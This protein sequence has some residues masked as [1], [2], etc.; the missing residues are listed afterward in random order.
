VRIIF[1]ILIC[2]GLHTSSTAQLKDAFRHSVGAG[3][4]LLQN[5]E[6]VSPAFGVYYHPQIN[7]INR[8]SDFSMSVGLPV[9]L[10][11]HIKSSFVPNTFFYAKVP[12]ITEANI[13]H[14]ATHDFT[15]SVGMT[16]GGG[17]AM[18]YTDLGLGHGPVATLS[19]RTWIKH[20]SI[21][22]RYLGMFQIPSSD[23]SGI[24]VPNKGYHTHM[25]V[26]AFNMGDYLSK[27][28]QM[29][30]ISKW[31]NPFRN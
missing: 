10:G 31:M 8:F 30:K 1:V 3:V 28:R 15:N 11:A 23:E 21:T 24:A 14:Y 26:L 2:F 12:L 13:G 5:K 7:Y 17:Y 27:V 20:V 18:Q 25:L 29:N 6:G 9:M 16:I 19:A 22:V 4:S